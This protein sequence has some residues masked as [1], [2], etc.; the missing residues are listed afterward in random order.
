MCHQMGIWRRIHPRRPCQGRRRVCAGIV[1]P[2]CHERRCDPDPARALLPGTS[3]GLARPAAW[4][5]PSTD[6]LGTPRHRTDVLFCCPPP[7]PNSSPERPQK[8]PHTR[9][10][11]RIVPQHVVPRTVR[12]P[13]HLVFSALTWSG[14][15]RTIQ[16]LWN[17]AAGSFS[18]ASRPP[19]T[20]P[21]AP[22]TGPRNLISRGRG[23]HQGSALRRGIRNGSDRLPIGGQGRSS[24]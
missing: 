17:V 1:V 3:R 2:I 6:R 5:G 24:K 20:S 9:T 19:G 23:T 14:A 12:Q 13:L 11:Y 18:R 8:R 10:P 7:I 4:R 16:G 22:G 21:K 15:R